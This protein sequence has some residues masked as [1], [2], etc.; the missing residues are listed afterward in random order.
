MTKNFVDILTALANM[1][2]LA[3]NGHFTACF[4]V[5]NLVLE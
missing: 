3:G 2:T 4:P 5:K 1:N